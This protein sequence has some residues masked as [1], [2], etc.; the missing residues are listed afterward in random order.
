MIVARLCVKQFPQRPL[1]VVKAFGG[2]QCLRVR[3]F[4]AQRTRQRIVQPFHDAIFRQ[5]AD[6][7]A[8]NFAINE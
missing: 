8:N 7:F 6:K 1:G 4:M 3:E 5:R 2:D